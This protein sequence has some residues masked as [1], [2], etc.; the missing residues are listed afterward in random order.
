MGKQSFWASRV[1]RNLRIASKDCKG[2]C[3]GD[4]RVLAIKFDGKP[5]LGHHEEEN[6]D[7]MVGGACHGQCP[8]L[9]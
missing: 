4:P 3:R 5:L 1:F 6:G 8:C 7:V 9:L 2:H